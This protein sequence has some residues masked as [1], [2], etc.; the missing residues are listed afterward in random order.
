MFTVPGTLTMFTTHFLTESSQQL[1]E[2]C[3]YYLLVFQLRKLST[4]KVCS[5]LTITQQV[6]NSWI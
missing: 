3:Y 2:R 4:S 1:S 5:L 6:N